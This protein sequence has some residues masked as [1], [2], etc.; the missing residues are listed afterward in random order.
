MSAKEFL[1]VIDPS[2]QTQPAL[3]RAI[4]SCRLTGDKLHLFECING[5]YYPRNSNE[6]EAEKRAII[7]QGFQQQLDHMASRI[8]QIG[9]EVSQELIWSDNWRNALV[10]S[11]NK[12]KPYIVFKSSFFHTAAGR[13]QE[14]SDWSLLR[15]CSSPILLTHNISGWENRCVLAAVNMAATGEKHI[16]LNKKVIETAQRYAR[17]YGATVHYVNAF[18]PVSERESDL[19]SNDVL[20]YDFCDDGADDR[21]EMTPEALASFCDADIGNVHLMAMPADQAILT[22]A[23]K[24]DVDL[25]IVGTVKRQGMTA[26]FIGNT[27]EKLIDKTTADVLTLS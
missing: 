24:L 11:I 14:N 15:Q 18:T 4:Q 7:T 27:A 17:G 16:E 25:I 3:E 8:K 9:L 23:K 21:T 19:D 22:T 13:R 10:E 12:R 2:Q 6:S 26:K 5:S 1:V 20:F